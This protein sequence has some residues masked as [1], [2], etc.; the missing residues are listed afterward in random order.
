MKGGT[1]KV[2]PRRKIQIPKSDIMNTPYRTTLQRNRVPFFLRLWLGKKT[3]VSR[4]RTAIDSKL[5][6]RSK[7]KILTLA[8]ASPGED[9]ELES[10]LYLSPT[11]GGHTLKNLV[12]SKISVFSWPSSV[13]YVFPIVHW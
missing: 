10:D 13:L 2:V 11:K 5:E 12:G 6:K 7:G 3:S 9:D 8:M 1:L 4:S